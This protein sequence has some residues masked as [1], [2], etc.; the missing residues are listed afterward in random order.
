MLNKQLCATVD[1]LK[2]LA[3]QPAVHPPVLHLTRLD[4]RAYGA[5]MVHKEFQLFAC[6]T[7]EPLKLKI[8]W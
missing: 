2:R 1:L 8:T 5:A 4:E 6:K 3:N 7:T